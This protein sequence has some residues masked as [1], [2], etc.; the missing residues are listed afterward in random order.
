ML[1]TD[2]EHFLYTA[3]NRMEHL[4]SKKHNIATHW[5]KTRSSQ[6]KD[7]TY[8]TNKITQTF[9]ICRQCPIL[10]MRNSLDYSLVKNH[11]YQLSYFIYIMTRL[12]KSPLQTKSN[13]PSEKNHVRQF[14]INY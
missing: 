5:M 8:A 10:E 11:H 4:L 9:N 2:E 12:I 3:Q 13:R 1:K 14:A 7:G 6:Q